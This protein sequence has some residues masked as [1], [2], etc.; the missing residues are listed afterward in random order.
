MEMYEIAIGTMCQ[1]QLIENVD[2]QKACE[3][4]GHG[5]HGGG[6]IVRRECLIQRK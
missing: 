1:R 3:D 5:R 2:G 6:K 4:M